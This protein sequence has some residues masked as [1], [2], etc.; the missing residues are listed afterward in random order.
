MI[1]VLVT[2]LVVLFVLRY[3][4]RNRV[5]P[6]SRTARR[7]TTIEGWERQ[8]KLRERRGPRRRVVG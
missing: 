2:L 3:L 4:R 1:D 8:C 6:R 7:R 5:G